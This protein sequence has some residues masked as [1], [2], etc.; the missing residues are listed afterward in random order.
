MPQMFKCS[1]FNVRHCAACQGY[2]WACCYFD[3]WLSCPGPSRFRRSFMLV[4]EGAR[5]NW[6]PAFLCSSHAIHTVNATEAMSQVSNFK[7]RSIGSECKKHYW[8]KKAGD[9]IFIKNF[10]F[11]TRFPNMSE[12][13]LNRIRIL[14]QSS[15]R[16]KRHRKLRKKS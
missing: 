14:P 1:V 5:W 11:P 2:I 4:V 8:Y 7:I 16:E 15:W 10:F 12:N 6:M 13:V 3:I 9:V